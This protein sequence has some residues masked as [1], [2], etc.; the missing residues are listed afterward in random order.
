MH[1]DKIPMSGEE[2][3]KRIDQARRQLVFYRQTC[4]RMFRDLSENI[5][6]TVLSEETGKQAQILAF[7]RKTPSA[8]AGEEKAGRLDS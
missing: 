4:H 5:N 8:G 2:R 3:R 1:T 7:L 6:H